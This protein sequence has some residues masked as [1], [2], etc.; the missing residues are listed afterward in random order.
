MSTFEGKKPTILLVCDEP[1][2]WG[3]IESILRSDEAF[4]VQ[5]VPNAADALRLSTEIEVDLIICREEIHAAFTEHCRLA[6]KNDCPLLSPLLLL[7]ADRTNPEDIARSL[8]KG[9][10]DFIERHACTEILL[11]KVRSLLSKKLLQR[12]LW[13][14]EKRLEETNDLLERSYRELTTVLLKMLEVRVPG[15]SDRSETAK[16][17]ADFLTERLGLRDQQRKHIVLAAL[18]HEIGKVGLPD[19]AACKH[20]YS[21]PA[22]LLPVF[23]QHVTV[24][25]MI[26]S[27]ITGYREAAETVHHQLENF[28]GSGAPDGLMGD[29]IP[30][31][32]RILRTIVF[33]E[34]LRAE[35]VPLEGIMERIRSAMH[36]ILDQR[37]AN[38]LIEFLLT[39]VAEVRANELKLPVDELAAGMVVAQ[40]IFA[41]SGVKLLPK[42]IPLNEKTLALL[43]E[44]NETDP[45]IGGVY[46][47]SPVPA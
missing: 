45:I 43:F 14:K 26:I 30:I 8:E 17:I 46:V 3:A 9:A 20:Y 39:R 35:Q 22:S 37:I 7:L 15:T 41:A 23:Q 11:P 32:A 19:E 38:L 6:G 13:R 5:C 10:D 42:G 40:D 47:V 28:D 21:L 12:D 1:E 29:E 4:D 27:T 25:S 36:S 44:R 34:E 31:G 2:V 24:G 16:A 18:L 33:H